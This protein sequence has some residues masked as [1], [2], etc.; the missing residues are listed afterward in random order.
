[1]F[2]VNSPALATLLE[3]EVVVVVFEV[4]VGFVVSRNGGC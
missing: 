4:V 1:M 3:E 2:F